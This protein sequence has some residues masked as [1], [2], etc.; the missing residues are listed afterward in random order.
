[1]RICPIC[2]SDESLRERTLNNID[3]LKCNNCDFVYSDL[4]ESESEKTNSSYDDKAIEAYESYQNKFDYFWMKEIVSKI[5]K[6]IG[7][8]KV[9]D[10]GCGNGMLLSIF[11]KYGW[12]CYGIDLSPWSEKYSKK[13][14][15]RLF[16]GKVEELELDE[17]DYDLVT[18][19]STLE[20]IYDP[21]PHIKR[22]VELIKPGGMSY[23]SG[24]PNYDSLSIRMGFS[25]FNSNHPPGHANYFTPKTMRRVVNLANDK[26]ENIEI[27][28]YGIPELHRLKRFIN[29]K[30]KRKGS[31]NIIAEAKEKKAY[32]KNDF[33]ANFVVN[34][35]YFLGRPL[36]LG[37]KIEVVIQK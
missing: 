35:N 18:S 9:L 13:Y 22:I 26:V 20:H 7:K 10:V 15:Y 29:S 4:K 27:R 19:T 34:A 2:S 11:M 32:R 8:G 5:S 28:T 12:D 36:S 23:F 33:L 31:G 30:K 24:I 6:K 14:G 17:E 25:T 21:V 16:R 3:L 37:D 1:M